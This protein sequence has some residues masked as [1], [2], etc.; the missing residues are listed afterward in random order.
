MP[1]EDWSLI[2]SELIAL[3]ADFAGL[4]ER[5]CEL[6]VG[7]GRV[8]VE[9][10]RLQMEIAQMELVFARRQRV[11]AE[12]AADLACGTLRGDSLGVPDAAR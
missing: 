3:R 5:T 11:L 6:D 7:V 9:M 4:A 12:R 8:E 10:A 1:D 2:L